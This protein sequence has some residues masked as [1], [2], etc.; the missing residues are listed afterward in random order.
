[1]SEVLC[2]PEV[3]IIHAMSH[4]AAGTQ[5]QCGA[6]PGMGSAMELRCGFSLL[7]GHSTRASS[8]A[9]YLPLAPLLGV[10]GS[11]FPH[12]VPL[13]FLYILGHHLADVGA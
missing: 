9:W 11:S 6:G 13:L 4:Q 5:L 3:L 12:S 10:V 2:F 7:V 8:G 1:M